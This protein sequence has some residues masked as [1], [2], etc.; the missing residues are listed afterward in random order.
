M[1]EPA[2]NAATVGRDSPRSALAWRFVAEGI[3]R[4]AAFLTMPLLARLVGA[5]GYGEF[6]LAQASIAAL[7]P[8]ASLGLGFSLVRRIAGTLEPT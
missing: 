2:G 4:A 6:T 7:V 3:G 5:D 8:V 1:A